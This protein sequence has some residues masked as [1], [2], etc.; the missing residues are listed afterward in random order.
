MSDRTRP[1]WH[2]MATSISNSIDK[3]IESAVALIF[4]IIVIVGL[5]QVGNRFLLNQSLSWSEELQ[6]FG[7]IWLIFLAIPV[8]YR[9]SA[10]IYMD[11]FREKYPKWFAGVFDWF[12]ELIW[13]GFALCLIFLTLKVASV[14]AL[15][16]SPGLG[17]SMNYPYYGMVIGGGYLLFCVIRRMGG[18]LLTLGE[19][20]K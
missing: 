20:T 6:K 1:K 4:L 5:L 14:A 2:Q 11:F 7:H 10:H 15:Q 3:I 9:R 16:T 13:I 17:I 18:M 12:V 8:A 19:K